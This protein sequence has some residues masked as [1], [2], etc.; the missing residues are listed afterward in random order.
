MAISSSR[1]IKTSFLVDLSD[2][3]VNLLLAHLS[4]SAVM[5][6]EALQ[7]GADLTTSGLLWLGL[8][9][10]RRRAD[11]EHRF[12]YGREIYFWTLMAAVCMLIVTATVTLSRGWAHLTQPPLLGYTAPNL[13]VLFIALGTNG[14]AFSLSWR[15]LRQATGDASIV[16]AFMSSTLIETKTT[17]VLDLMGSA[18]AVFGFASLALYA[19]TGDSRFDG[20]GAVA[21]AVSIVALAVL[22]IFDVKDLLIGR[23]A[24]VKIEAEIKA[25]AEAV[26]GVESVR[27]VRTMY[28]GSEQ[29]LIALDINFGRA[30]RAAKIDHLIEKVKDKIR[31]AVPTARHIQIEL[32]T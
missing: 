16:Q 24:A 14:Y 32:E 23:G 10:S 5:L 26:K 31:A 28:V 19:T 13:I 2:F 21:I 3:L 17:F 25:T 18:S 9:R 27:R 1:V 30:H 11:R 12:G 6:A 4:G 29:L 15:R 8:K 20:L 7:G 22:L